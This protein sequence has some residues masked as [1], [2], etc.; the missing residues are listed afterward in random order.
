[1]VTWADLNKRQQTYLKSVYEVDQ[2]QEANIKSAGAS[3]RWNN[4]P[5]SVWRWMPYN[6]A[7]APLLEKIQGAGYRDEGTGS[8][9]AALERRGL[10]L[11]KYE[12][13]PLGFSIL[14]VQ[15]TKEGRKMVRDA[16]GI[17]APKA[18]A[19]GT[20]QEWHWRALAKAYTAGEHG[21]REE[22]ISYGRI[23][24]NTWVRLRNYQ[25]HGVDYPLIRE[26]NGVSI[27]PFGIGYYE[28]SFAR[29]HEMY[30]EVDAPQPREQHHPFDPFVEVI[31]NQ[32][33]C[34][35]CHGEYPVAVTR[36]Y[37]Q[38]QKWAWSVEDRATRIP[39]RVTS[40]YGKIEHCLCREE[41]IQEVSTTFLTLLDQIAA[42]GWQLSFP[43]HYWFDY[44]DYLVGG[45]SLGREPRWYAPELVR[46][47]L[48][49]LLD[50][51]EMQEERNILKSEIR[52][53]YNEEVGK[54]SVYALASP[55][56]FKK[57]PVAFTLHT[58]GTIDQSGGNDGS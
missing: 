46:Q 29:Y 51:R 39:G 58:Y 9:F 53:C 43:Y 40:K 57:V 49:P 4:T 6:A 21:V 50:D 8:T 47:K 1:M 13:D 20:L 31:Q 26:R 36:T 17:K 45:V 18:P 3:G 52:Y 28:R 30:P 25:I 19:V 33:T 23:G 37:Q 44:L 24:W 56:N 34:R 22:G 54:G 12:Q 55:G 15:I 16:L 38:D 48:L 41:A 27:T 35:A 11:C 32:R 7:D 42:Q 5:A 10:V 2:L 14:F